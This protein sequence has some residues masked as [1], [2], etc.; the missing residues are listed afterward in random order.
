MKVG[1]LLE[2]GEM[3]NLLAITFVTAIMLCS[4]GPSQR[5]L[6]V[7]KTN[8][9]REYAQKGDTILALNTLDSIKRLYPKAEMQ[10]SI[11]KNYSDE[12]LRSLIDTR[13]SQL[14]QCDTI[15]SDLEKSFVKEKTAF[16]RYTQYIHNR[17]TFSRSWK[18]SYLQIN[19]DERGELF[20]TSNYMGEEW[21]NHTSIMVYDGDLKMKSGKVELDNPMNNHSDF[22]KNKWE[23]VSYTQGKSDSVIHFIA[24]HPDHKLKCVFQGDR[25]YYIL[26]EE[27][28]VKA[29]IEAL[30]LSNAI[31]SKT[32]ASEELESYKVRRNTLNQ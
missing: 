27:Y 8:Q 25:Y 26:L 21:L 19:L 30:N 29:V 17:Q 20:L 32:K 1:F 6:A 9:A 13:I 16:D 10:I 12:L 24:E 11:A 18:R 2:T 14:E 15:I 4:C 22:L 3:K 5:E 7:W 23:K 28:D 31:K